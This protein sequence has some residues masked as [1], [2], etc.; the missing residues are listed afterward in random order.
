[1]RHPG[2]RQGAG[3]RYGNLAFSVPK[4]GIIAGCIVEGGKITRN[5]AR[6]FLEVGLQVPAGVDVR[7]LT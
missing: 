4:V 1:M 3:H 7:Y 6:G 5:A 2:Q